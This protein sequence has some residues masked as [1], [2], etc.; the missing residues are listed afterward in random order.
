VTLPKHIQFWDD[1]RGIGNGIIVTLQWGFSFYAGEHL[2]VAG[3]DS[4]TEARAKTRRKDVFPCECDRCKT[5]DKLS[6]V[7]PL[8]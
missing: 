4:L 8:E 7:K 6:L 1:E 2:G 3:F 5:G